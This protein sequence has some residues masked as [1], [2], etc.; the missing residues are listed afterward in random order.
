LGNQ[1]LFQVQLQL[2]GQAQAVTLTPFP[3]L[4]KVLV[5]ALDGSG[6]L[7]NTRAQRSH[8]AQDRRRPGWVVV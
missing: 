1:D 2:Y 4:L 6:K 7:W 3:A 8:R 5:V